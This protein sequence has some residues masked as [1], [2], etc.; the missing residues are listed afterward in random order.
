MLLRCLAV[1]VSAELNCVITS[2]TQLRESIFC[3]FLY[4]DVKKMIQFLGLIKEINAKKSW[5]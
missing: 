4:P 2:H 3:F 1:P 5:Y